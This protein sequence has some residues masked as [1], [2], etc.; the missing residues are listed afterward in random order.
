M[1]KNTNLVKNKNNG[2][3]Q[4]F[5]PKS[6]FRS[7]IKSIYTQTSLNSASS[8]YILSAAHCFKILSLSK[9]QRQKLTF[10]KYRI[11]VGYRYFYNTNNISAEELAQHS[12][13][14]IKKVTFHP[15]Y[16]KDNIERNDMA[17]LELF[18]TNKDGTCIQFNN[19]TQVKL[20][21]K[22]FRKVFYKMKYQ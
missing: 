15:Q 4:N 5:G 8:C 6:K 2:E 10:E 13:H 1:I 7:K 20:F 14:Y 16:R 12:A 9:S 17:L 3:R 22:T 18:A 19:A 11:D 21:F